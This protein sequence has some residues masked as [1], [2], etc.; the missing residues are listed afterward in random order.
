MS[1]GRIIPCLLLRSRG[2]YKTVKFKDPRY[3]GDPINAVKIFNDKGVDELTILDIGASVEGC[4]PDFALIESIVSEAF[5]PICYGG[6]VRTL[7]Q[8][9]RLFRLGVEKVS[10][11]TA[12]LESTQ[13]IKD[14]AARFGSQSVVASIDVKR[15]MFG[16]YEVYGRSG[17]SRSRQDPVELAKSL[18]A[19]GA[20]ELVISAIHKDGTMAG[21]DLQLTRSIV[22]AVDIPVVALG[23]AGKVADLKAAL[24][25]GASAAAA[26]SMFVFHGPHRAVLISYP[27]ES[28]LGRV[29]DPT[30]AW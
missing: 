11:N 15:T 19:A 17:T 16:G 30:D 28:E 4:E 6:G 7:E 21:F 20:G 10:V 5:V 18:Q 13:L 1:G 29:A 3:V 26:G 22:E 8:F 14:A 24:A 27:S 25:T 9:S 12:A 2:L 23:G